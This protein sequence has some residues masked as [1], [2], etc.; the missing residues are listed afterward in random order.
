MA[1][2]K[3][4]HLTSLL[5]A[6]IVVLSYLVDLVESDSSTVDYVVKEQLTGFSTDKKLEHITVCSQNLNN[7]N[8]SSKVKPKNA[9]QSDFLVERFVNASCDIIAVQELL[10]GSKKEAERSL[11][12]LAKKL[13]K[14]TGD[15]YQIIV[16]DAE[17]K[18]ITNGYLVSSSVAEIVSVHDYSRKNIPR[19]SI[20]GPGRIFSRG[21]LELKLRLRTSPNSATRDLILYN[22]HFKSKADG[23]K[24]KTGTSYETLRMEMAEGLR[25]IIEA[26]VK[27]PETV[28]MVLGDRNSS[29]GSATDEILSG[30]RTL[31]DFSERLIC[32][33]SDELEPLCKE[34]ARVK[35]V[36]VGL[37]SEALKSKQ[38]SGGSYRYKG[39]MYLLDEIYVLPKD[40]SRFRKSNNQPNVGI[41]G[42]F[43]KGSDHK[44]VYAVLSL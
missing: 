32:R 35:T 20:L 30:K 29:S 25:N 16:G 44:L 21:P 5:I 33:L 23:W 42:V 8:F 18:R 4:S 14:Q 12:Y 24:D 22:I 17:D 19:L 3:I 6:L 43:G 34:E 2:T 9:K 38:L 7:Y 39:Q 37:I 31:E 36:L 11:K 26:E 15:T 41:E 27:A 28:V 1:K 40:N 13:S 10:R